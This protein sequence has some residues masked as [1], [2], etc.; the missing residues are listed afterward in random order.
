MHTKRVT[1]DTNDKRKETNTPTEKTNTP[2]KN[3]DQNLSRRILNLSKNTPLE[4]MI[5]MM[6]D[7]INMK[8]EINTP[9]IERTITLITTEMTEMIEVIETLTNIPNL[10]LGI[11]MA[12]VIIMADKALVLMDIMVKIQD[13]A[14]K[15]CR[16]IIIILHKDLVILP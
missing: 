14:I 8:K 3:N 5:D 4:V 9:H 10:I 1:I 16:D 15:I 2:I 7:K 11:K 6:I 12:V 13:M